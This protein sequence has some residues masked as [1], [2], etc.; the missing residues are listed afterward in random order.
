VLHEEK[1][2]GCVELA[3]AALTAG[4]MMRFP[5]Y[6]AIRDVTRDAT[7][8]LFSAGLFGAVLPPLPPF[9]ARVLRLRRAMA[10]AARLRLTLVDDTG[11]LADTTF[12][13]VL[14]A[15]GDDRIVVVAGFPAANAVVGARRPTKPNESGAGA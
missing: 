13:N 14:H 10:R 3:A 2:V 15:L 11:A 12:V 1:P 8:A 4:R 6:G 9:P 5:A 7:D